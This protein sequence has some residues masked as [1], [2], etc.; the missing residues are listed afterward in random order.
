MG[1]LT[2][3]VFPQRTPV[4]NGAFCMVGYSYQSGHKVSALVTLYSEC[5]QCG[6]CHQEKTRRD[7]AHSPVA[8]IL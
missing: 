3:L 5:K 4:D 1:I 6:L 7:D 8:W 2:G